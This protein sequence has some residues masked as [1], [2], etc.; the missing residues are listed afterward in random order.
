MREKFKTKGPIFEVVAR[1]QSENSDNLKIINQIYT[2]AINM[3]GGLRN[4]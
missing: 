1:R 4:P 3:P 2:D